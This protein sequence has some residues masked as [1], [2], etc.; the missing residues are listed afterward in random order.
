[1][2]GHRLSH[3]VCG[4]GPWSR[5]NDPF[6]FYPFA[7]PL[8]GPCL[9]P[10]CSLAHP[11]TPPPPSYHPLS[12]A[13][14][15]CL[16]APPFLPRTHCMFRLSLPLLLLQ[17][18]LPRAAA[19]VLAKLD[20]PNITKFADAFEMN[21]ILYIVM[22]YADGGDLWARIQLQGPNLMS[23]E[24]CM[25]YFVQLCL[26]LHHMHS[27][28]ILHRDL[29]AANVFLTSTNMVKL[30][31]FGIST[32]L[33]HTMSMAHTKCG[34]PYYFSPEVLKRMLRDG[35]PLFRSA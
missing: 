29:K 9:V 17:P 2:I 35:H 33:K 15:Y 24:L 11:S 25:H 22:E 20:H 8:L 34:T 14:L 21:Q 1:M 10:S 26:A 4:A 3:L 16:L 5:L 13:P 19:Q 28:K 6:P 32:I 27:Q 31:D 23:E 18:L 7:A 12:V 30:G